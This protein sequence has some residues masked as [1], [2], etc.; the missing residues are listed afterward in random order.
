MAKL[1]QFHGKCQKVYK[2]IE[3]DKK[4]QIKMAQN[5]K[6]MQNVKKLQIH[7]KWQTNSNS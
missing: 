6:F 7:R 1:I 2:F 4:I 5:Y 3:N